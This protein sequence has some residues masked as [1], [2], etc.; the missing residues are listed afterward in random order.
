[1]KKTY[2]TSLPD[3]AGAFQA[4]SEIIASLG[5][6]ITRVSYNKAVDLHML[7]VEVDG[8]PEAIGQATILLNNAGYILGSTDF[9]RMLLLDFILP[10]RPG[11]VLP[12]LRLINDR[13][14]NISYISSQADG[15]DTQR[16]RIGFI[17]SSDDEATRFLRD[18]AAR[19]RIE[20]ISC[21]KRGQVLD[22]TVFYLS[23]ANSIASRLGLT[24]EQE[25]ELIV[26]SNLIM[27][28]LRDTPN[29]Q[30]DT[31]N[32]ISRFADHMCAH[33]GGAFSCRVSDYMIGPGVSA[34]LI[35]PPCG[36]NICILDCGGSLIFIDGGFCCYEG[37]GMAE[38]RR[39]YPD[40]DD[41]EKSLI[42]T[43]ADVDHCG[44]A[45]HFADIYTSGAC[46]GNFADEQ[47]GRDNLREVNP[48]HKPYVIISKLLSGYRSVPLVPLHSVGERAPGD[49]R[50]LAYIGKLSLYG[51]SFEVF[52]GLGGHTPGE[53]VLIERSLRLVF[54]GDI[55][56]NVKGCIP[57]QHEFNMLA[58]YLMTSVDT[59]PELAKR[60]R[61]ELFRL[62][63][64][65]SWLVFG[66]HGA[67]KRV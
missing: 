60:E 45:D 33:H 16:F 66:G 47:A 53:S 17:V 64:P 13:G 41:R 1:M 37:E 48:I 27:E 67:P 46:C 55:F 29:A 30:Y 15:G 44:I 61:D 5:L 22:N 54:S 58:P 28:M 12:V 26:Q 3:K 57:V 35:E 50:S 32:Y 40:F 14:I 6:N 20:I 39:L 4:A 10:D 56:I 59:D 65:G 38:I 43:H 51:L 23:F 18:A 11:T 9:G 24:A 36:S 7:F 2:M 62:M 21:E 25:S 42:L 8:A 34:K 31:F 19:F 49:E 52:E 63:G